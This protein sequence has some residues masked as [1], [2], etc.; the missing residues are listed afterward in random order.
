M[1]FKGYYWDEENAKTQ[2]KSWIQKYM[3]RTAWLAFPVVQGLLELRRTKTF[4]PVQ[5]TITEQTSW[6]GFYTVELWGPKLPKRV[7][8]SSILSI[9]QGMLMI[10][11]FWVCWKWLEH[12]LLCVAFWVF[13]HSDYWVCFSLSK[14]KKKEKKRLLGLFLVLWIDGFCN[15]HSSNCLK[16]KII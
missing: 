10:F 11:S 8:A 14:K 15:L 13:C 9:S 4:F 1:R 7:S 12:C 2:S 16:K 3:K 5:S 6:T